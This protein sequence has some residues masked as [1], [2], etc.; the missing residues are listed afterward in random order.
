MACEAM[1]SWEFSGLVGAFLD[2]AITYFLLCASTIAYFASKFLGIFGLGLPCPCNGLFGNPNSNYC[3]HTLLYD[4]PNEKISSLQLSVKTKFPFDSIRRKDHNCQMNLKLVRGKSNNVYECVEME[5]E[6]SCSSISDA[7]KPQN[8][9][10]RDLIPRSELALGSSVMNLPNFKDRGFDLKGKGIMSQRPRGGLRRRRKGVSDYGRISSAS[11]FNSLRADVQGV[12]GSPSSVNSELNEAIEGRSV[13]VDSGGDG[14]R[15]HC[16]EDT[17]GFDFN[18]PLDEIKSKEQNDTTVEDIKSDAT[19]ELGFDNSEKNAIRILEQALGDGHAACAACAALYVELDKERS[20]AASAADEAMAMILRLQE[21]KASIE[22]EARQYQRILEEKSA[23]DAEEMNILKEILVR[24]EREMHF[25][26]KEVECYRQ[27]I[28]LRNEDL[29]GNVQDMESQRQDFA[30]ALDMG[31]DPVLMLHHLSESIDKKEIVKS[32]SDV[33]VLSVNEPNSVLAVGNAL[34]VPVLDDG[35]DLL[36][37]EDVEEQFSITSRSRNILNQ[38]FQEKGMVS[39]DNDQYAQQGEGCRSETFSESYRSSSSQEGYLLEKTIPLVDDEVRKDN[40]NLSQG[41]A[42][43]T[44]ETCNETEIYIPQDG[45]TMEQ[46]AKDTEPRVHDV[47]VIK[48]ES[49]L[50]KGASENQNELLSVSDTSDVH[51]KSDLP[52]RVADM[53]KIGIK[54]DCQSTSRLDTETVISRTSSDMTT[55]LPPMGRSRSKASFLD[56][57]RPSMS[58]LDSER[59]KIDSE[60]GWLRERL[61]IVQEGREKLNFSVEHREREKIQLQLLEDIARQL[62]EIRLLTEPGKAVRQASLPLPSSKVLSKKRRYRS[63]SIGVNKSS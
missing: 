3:L 34:P 22:M 44:I 46:H 36:K 4:C 32:S 14:G 6:E 55:G 57:R 16:N 27:M 42:T 13:P 1:E 58:S 35:A 29:Q 15:S 50:C 63:A 52:S 11:S 43:K 39:M 10:R 56:L 38:E 31:E 60:V 19:G 28:F 8:L 48:D 54:S 24:R 5:G 40:V 18:E 26:E 37:Q 49:N 2:L 17:R 20:A 25:L 62:R 59:L 45:K 21:E 30:S 23:Y 53:K 51:R 47:H 41:M 61:R 33:G 12:P 9:V 7:R